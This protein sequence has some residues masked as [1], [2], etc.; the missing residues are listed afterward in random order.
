MTGYSTVLLRDDRCC[1]WASLR[2][3]TMKKVVPMKNSDYPNKKGV[4]P[5][6]LPK[7]LS[8]CSIQ[9]DDTEELGSR[10][11]INPQHPMPCFFPMYFSLILSASFI[12][13][14]PPATAACAAGAATVDRNLPTLLLSQSIA[15]S[16]R[17]RPQ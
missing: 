6:H 13:F 7:T 9:A 5:I 4:P 16:L 15:N 1:Q 12:Y 14:N 8:A 10:M 11:R 2:K 3:S 17:P